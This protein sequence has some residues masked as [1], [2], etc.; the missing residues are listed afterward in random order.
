[1]NT[2]N[3]AEQSF[4]HSTCQSCV[5]NPH[6]HC[7]NF[8][9]E[10]FQ[11]NFLIGL[12]PVGSSRLEK[13]VIIQLHAF[14]LYHAYTKSLVFRIKMHH[15]QHSQISLF[16]LSFSLLSASLIRENLLSVTCSCSNKS[17]LLVGRSQSWGRQG[18]CLSA[19]Q[20]I[21]AYGGR[22]TN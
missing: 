15:F 19:S 11:L 7:I 16:P 13:N 8:A 2:N 9:I 21:H 18:N 3:S 6:N 20:F 14:L 12:Q 5:T 17:W 22:I 4:L 10:V 1:M